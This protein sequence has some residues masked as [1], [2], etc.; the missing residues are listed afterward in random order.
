M[1]KITPMW[2]NNAMRG[3]DI[4]DIRDIN[5]CVLTLYQVADDV[6][7]ISGEIV[8]HGNLNHRVGTGL[9]TQ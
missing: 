5:I 6:F 9:L 3:R 2:L 1:A 8:N 4:R 7:A